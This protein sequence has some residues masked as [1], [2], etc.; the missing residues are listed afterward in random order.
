MISAA[1]AATAMLMVT[2]V[3]DHGLEYLFAATLLVNFIQ[4]CAGFLTLGRV[5]R[6]VS[7]TVITD[8]IKALATFIFMA[9]LPELI[10]VPG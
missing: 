8:F 1:T 7:R 5:M 10:G 2:L 9:H 6:F 4:I 3:K